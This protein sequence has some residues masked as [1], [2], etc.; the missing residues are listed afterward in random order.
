MARL[1]G[2]YLSAMKWAVE[3]GIIKGDGDTGA[4]KADANI[5]RAEMVSVLTRYSNAK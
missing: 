5:T 4:L 1:E 2:D 3:K